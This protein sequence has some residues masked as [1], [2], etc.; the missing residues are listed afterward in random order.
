[1]ADET[2]RHGCLTAFLVVG[3][4]AN[5]IVILMYT[6]GS[7]AM[8]AIQPNLPNWALP[9]LVGLGICNIAFFLAVFRWRRWGFY[10]FIAT[11]VIAVIVNLSIGLSVVSSLL[12]LS[13]A[14]ILYW[15]LQMGG[16]NNGWR[17][18]K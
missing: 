6:L 1:M 18:L 2:S 14:A 4:A 10:G 13:G 11:S 5:T 7:A 16:Q 15:V 8:Q 9:V 12:G 3:I 17:Q